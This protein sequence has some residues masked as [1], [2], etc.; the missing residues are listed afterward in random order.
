MAAVME[1]PLLPEILA[2]PRPAGWD[3]A[4]RARSEAREA[5]NGGG[6]GGSAADE[7]GDKTRDA[8]AK[9]RG[10]GEERVWRRVTAGPRSRG[11]RSDRPDACDEAASHAQG[12]ASAAFHLLKH[13]TSSSLRERY[14]FRGAP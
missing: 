13:P 1:R 6:G 9:E 10:A 8:L 4:R 5:G 2:Q 12:G 7:D 3:A 14:A 11:S